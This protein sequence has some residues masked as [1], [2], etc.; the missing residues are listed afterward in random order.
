LLSDPSWP[1]PN[2]T[3][4]NN[5]LRQS[6]WQKPAPTEETWRELVR[7]RIEMFDWERIL[8]DVRP[9]IESPS[10]LDLVSREN[11]DRVLRV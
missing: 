2:L 8:A 3:L 1:A 9:F 6:G 11:V 4:L 5:A 7:Q 10:E